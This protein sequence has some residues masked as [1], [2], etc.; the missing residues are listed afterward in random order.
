MYAPDGHIQVPGTCNQSVSIVES[1]KCGDRRDNGWRKRRLP[2]VLGT[3]SSAPFHLGVFHSSTYFLSFNGPFDNVQSQHDDQHSSQLDS[4]DCELL[5]CDN[6]KPVGRH[7]RPLHFC[8]T[9]Q[10]TSTKNVHHMIFYLSQHSV[11]L[12][13]T[14]TTITRP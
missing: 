2:T 13:I 11:A 1:N 6:K 4:Q 5:S 12:F 10:T 7:S 3:L 14:I 9:C 8:F